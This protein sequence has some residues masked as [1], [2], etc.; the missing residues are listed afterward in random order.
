MLKEE[1]SHR[2]ETN[3]QIE[4]KQKQINKEGFDKE[5][6]QKIQASLDEIDRKGTYNFEIQVGTPLTIG[7]TVNE[8]ESTI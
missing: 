7:G 4:I 3:K 8:P 6:K 2:R 1:E 5:T